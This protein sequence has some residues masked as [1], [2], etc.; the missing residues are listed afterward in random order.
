MTY[1]HGDTKEVD[2]VVYRYDMSGT[3]SDN[4]TCNGCAATMN[5]PQ[6]KQLCKKLWFCTGGV[7]KIKEEA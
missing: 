5:T 3:N 6:G 1:K 4:N 7:W 2:G